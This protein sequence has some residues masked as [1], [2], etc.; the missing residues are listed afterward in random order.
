M[1][2]EYPEYVEQEK[3]PEKRIEDIPDD[4]VA[5]AMRTVDYQRCPYCETEQWINRVPGHNS[6]HECKECG[7]VLRV[8]G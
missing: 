5:Q 7:E 6:T 2:R 1:T 4:V 3:T 8:V